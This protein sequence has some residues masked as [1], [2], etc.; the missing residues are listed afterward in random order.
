MET[1]CSTCSGSNSRTSSPSSSGVE[2]ASRRR[3]VRSPLRS[4]SSRIRWSLRCW[5]RDVVL[6]RLI[7]GRLLTSQLLRDDVRRRVGVTATRARKSG[8]SV[9][10]APLAT[11]R[12]QKLPRVYRSAVPSACAANCAVIVT[13]HDASGDTGQNCDRG[14]L[15]GNRE[16]WPV[17]AEPAGIPFGLANRR[18]QPLGHLT[19]GFQVYET[20]TVTRKR[21]TLTRR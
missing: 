19:A 21:S 9:R 3:M 20:E 8:L 10:T 6:M 16:F 13:A 14:I 4:T 17:S 11:L 15:T 1:S 5:G 18:L 12:R 7:I 2:F